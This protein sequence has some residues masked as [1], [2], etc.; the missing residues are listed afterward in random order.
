[1]ASIG[2]SGTQIGTVTSMATAIAVFASTFWG[3]HNSNINYLEVYFLIIVCIRTFI[4]YLV[5]LFTL[6]AVFAST[7]WGNR[8][9]NSRDGR[10]VIALICLLAGA[11]AVCNSFVTIFLIFK[12]MVF[13]LENFAQ[14]FGASAING[15]SL[16]TMRRKAVP[17]PATLPPPSVKRKHMP[18]SGCNGC[19]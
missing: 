7:F 3:N 11:M 19:L 15:A 5:V 8:Y 6:I 4:L 1:M 9:A 12:A 13:S 18:F 14:S 2:F 17:T 16:P 10:K